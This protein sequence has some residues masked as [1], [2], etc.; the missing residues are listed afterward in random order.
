MNQ[1]ILLYGPE[2]SSKYKKALE[3]I[4][5]YSKSGLKYKRKIEI[6]LNGETYHYNISDVHFEIDFELLGTNEHGLWYEFMNQ[7]T[8]IVQTNIGI[9]LCRNF[10]MIDPELLAIFYTFMRNPR[11]KFILCTRNISFIPRN[12]KDICKIIALKKEGNELY[13]NQYKTSCDKIVDFIKTGEDLFLLRELIYQLF[14]YNYDIHLC[15]QYIHFEILRQCRLP[16]TLTE[17]VPIVEKYNTKYRSIYHLEHFCLTL[18]LKWN[19]G[20]PL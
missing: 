5:P 12:I 20:R 14:T 19:E 2:N 18:K 6:M 15:L 10:H 8:S 11:I 3:L 1:S 13:G 4:L 16:L 7:V 17:L 9:V